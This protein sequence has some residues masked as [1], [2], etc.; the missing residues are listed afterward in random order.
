MDVEPVL[1]LLHCQNITIAGYL[2]NLLRKQLEQ[3]FLNQKC[4]TES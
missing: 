1:V 4:D 2:D 3:V